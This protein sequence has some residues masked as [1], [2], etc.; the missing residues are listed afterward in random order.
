MGIIAFIVLGLIA[1][2]IA[3]AIVPGND[4]GGI[5][6]TTIVGIVG[7]L[8]GGFL[9]GVLFD[10]DPLDEFFDV[11]TWLTAIAGSIVLLVIYNAIVNRGGGGHVRV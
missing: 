8:F 7:A 10:A 4:P 2:I 5:I 11:S 1:G 6:L 9:A 3:K